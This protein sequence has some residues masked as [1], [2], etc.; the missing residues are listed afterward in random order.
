MRLPS[1]S[2]SKLIVIYL[3]GLFVII[4]FSF[5]SNKNE[6]GK[7]TCSRL[8]KPMV[9]NRHISKVSNVWTVLTNIGFIG[10]QLLDYPSFEWPG[11][12]G[13]NHMY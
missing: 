1:N 4:S 11:G 12:S 5:A 10:N 7:S 3:I 13:N 2:T 8:K 9:Y 6:Q